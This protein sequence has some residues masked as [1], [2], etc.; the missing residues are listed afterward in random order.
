MSGQRRA[1]NEGLFASGGEGGCIY[2]RLVVG[3][4]DG[5]VGVNV[6]V[7]CPL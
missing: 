1:I 2:R 4:R 3:K 7:I 6:I 5:K